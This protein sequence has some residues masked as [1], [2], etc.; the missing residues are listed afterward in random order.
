MVDVRF[1]LKFLDS[2]NFVKKILLGF[3]LA[4]FPI[5]DLWLFF[6]LTGYLDF[7]IL[8]SIIVGV[9]ILGFI[10]VLPIGLKMLKEIKA[11]IKYGSYPEKEFDKFAGLIFSAFLMILPGFISFTLGAIFLLPFLSHLIGKLF[12]SF[13]DNDLKEVYEYIKLY[14][15]DV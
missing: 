3:L 12:T 15:V 10:I 6:F 13:I 14:E 8:L 5:F 9:S 1:L 7:Y 11:K 4:I 2:G